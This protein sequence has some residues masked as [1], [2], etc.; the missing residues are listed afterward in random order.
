M[1]GHSSHSKTVSRMAE[2][3]ESWTKKMKELEKWV[4]YTSDTMDMNVRSAVHV[5]LMRMIRH[6]ENSFSIMCEIS[7]ITSFY[8]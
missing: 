4:W 7:L 1:S 8:Q 3:V 5:Q 6:R 2:R